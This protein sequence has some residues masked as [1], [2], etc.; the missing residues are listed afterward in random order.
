MWIFVG[1]KWIFDQNFDFSSKM[2]FLT[3]LWIFDQTF[4]YLTKI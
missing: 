1:E 4:G 2:R 3:K